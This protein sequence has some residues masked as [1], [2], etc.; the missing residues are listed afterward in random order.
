MAE[1]LHQSQHSTLHFNSEQD[2]ES[3][4]VRGTAPIT[5][6]DSALQ[7][8]KECW[9]ENMAD[10]MY[11]SQYSTLHFN[12]EQDAELSTWRD[13]DQSHYSILHFNSAQNSESS[14]GRDTAPI[15]ALN[16][17]L[18]WRTRSGTGYRERHCANH[19]TH[20][21]T[22]IQNRMLNWV[23][24]EILYN[25]HHLTLQIGRAHVWTPVTR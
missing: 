8:R 23:H 3:S 5:A 12:S 24:A 4:K 6:F 10:V 9:I 21:S 19:S 18:K 25:S 14:K 20:L 7:F 13:T 15:T 2:A 1:V 22:S 17:S 11:Q 16:S